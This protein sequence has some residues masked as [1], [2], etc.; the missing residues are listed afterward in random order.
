VLEDTVGTFQRHAVA[1]AVGQLMR[2]RPGGHKA[3]DGEVRG[4]PDYVEFPDVEVVHD[5]GLTLVCLV[6][7]KRVSVP[8]LEALPGSEMR[9]SR[10]RGRLVLPRPLAIELGLM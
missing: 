3:M 4:S 1:R 9:W 5:A 6:N 7:G 8:V 10:R 2:S